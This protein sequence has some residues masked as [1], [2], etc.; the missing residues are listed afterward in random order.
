MKTKWK[1][2]LVASLATCHAVAAPDFAATAKNLAA[3]TVRV[4]VALR[5]DGNT[6]PPEM[7]TRGEWCDNCH[8][9]HTANTQVMGY[10][11]PLD[12][13]GW[14][15]APDTV[16]VGDFGVS[17]RFTASIEVVAPGGEK[18]PA[19]RYAVFTRAPFT[20]L[21]TGAAIPGV[22]P[23]AFDAN[24]PAPAKGFLAVL[25]K[26][27]TKWRVAFEKT[28]FDDLLPVLTDRRGVF[29]RMEKSGLFL[30][31]DGT[32]AGF[33]FEGLFDPEKPLALPPF[34]TVEK[35]LE[36]DLAAVEERIAAMLHNGVHL[37]TLNFRSPRKNQ[38]QDRYY[39]GYG[40]DK[41]TVQYAAALHLAAGRF[42]VLKPLDARQT[43]RLES[44]SLLGND[45][46]NAPAEFVA[47]LAHFGAFVVASPGLA[48]TPLPLYGGDARDFEES[49]VLVAELGAPGPRMD[50]THDRA[51]VEKFY[52]RRKDHLSTWIGW[53]ENDTRL[54][55]TPR[56]ELLALPVREGS[57]A[58]D[59]YGSTM[60]FDAAKIVAL[61]ANLPAGEVDPVNIP[62]PARDENRLAWIGAVF[63]RADAQ[64]AGEMGIARFTLKDDG[65]DLE[66][67]GAL[68]SF[69]YP[70]S[71]ADKA[72]IK[73]GDVV[74]CAHVEGLPFPLPFPLDDNDCGHDFPWHKYDHAD[75]DEFEDT[76]APWP[77]MD[78][79]GNRRFT[80]LALGRNVRLACV[81]DGEPREVS[82]VAEASPVTY[83]AAPQYESE[84]LGLNARDLTYEARH[85]FRRAADDPGVI[86]SR[87]E[88]GRHAAVAG[89]RP[90]EMIL[91]V[92][93]AEVRD[94]AG[95]E[96]QIKDKTELQL[97]VR[98]MNR[99]RI[100][101]IN[102][103]EK[104]KP[105]EDDDEDGE[106]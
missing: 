103:A 53:K 101:L 4:E 5:Y 40:E 6:P 36:D 89:L 22:A 30:A 90:F 56:G 50:I 27:D 31:A 64:L 80:A 42:L 68:V 18:I 75:P 45:G 48:S 37:A 98:R 14:V 46:E 26:E 79:E 96:A 69:V 52:E 20:L 99:E 32:P 83:E 100:V 60:L 33:V 7:K 58:F 34:D 76:P 102:L 81:I 17:P 44:I 63:Q 19:R 77:A 41:S 84:A 70:G 3:S 47:S 23:P 8:N 78:N 87:V 43:A 72:G 65:G 105:V 106:D 39:W 55:F 21:K 104:V 85:Y 74:L 1:T 25:E 15:V 59:E 67:V 61:T 10:E 86:I 66:H 16:L 2:L 28:D 71:P 12:F 51:R 93:D 82:L 88:A 94:I 35:T 97:T 38:G 62:L 13:M 49:A 92:N 54:L 24:A 73:T 9:Y 91:K 95:F 11:R 57:A 29:S